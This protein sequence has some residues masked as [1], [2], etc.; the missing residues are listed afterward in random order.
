MSKQSSFDHP[1]ADSRLASDSSEQTA[2]EQSESAEP[3][4]PD[5]Y[6]PATPTPAAIDRLEKLVK[7]VFRRRGHIRA[8]R[9]RERED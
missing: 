7:S 8:D 3:H 2:P 5:F 6:L 4:R 1:A 9:H